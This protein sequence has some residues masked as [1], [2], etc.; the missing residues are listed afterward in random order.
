MSCRNVSNSE[1]VISDFQDEAS[2]TRPIFGRFRFNEISFVSCWRQP[3][4]AVKKLLEHLMR[5]E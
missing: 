1:K 2:M 3:D 4:T 5:L